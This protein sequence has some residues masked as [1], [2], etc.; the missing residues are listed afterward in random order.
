MPFNRNSCCRFSLETNSVV[1]GDRAKART[2]EENDISNNS[3]GSLC[4]S[5]NI[6]AVYLNYFK[7][8]NSLLIPSVEE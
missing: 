6:E 7:S 4:E 1:S 8:V 3:G 2:I 5:E